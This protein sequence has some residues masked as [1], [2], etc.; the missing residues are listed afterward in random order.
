MITTFQQVL[1]V[2]VTLGQKIRV[3]EGPDPDGGTLYLDLRADR[4][5]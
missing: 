5:R 2:V 1:H 4:A 3:A